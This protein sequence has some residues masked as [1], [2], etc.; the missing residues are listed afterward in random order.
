MKLRLTGGY[1]AAFLCL[2]I[3]CGTSHEFVNHFAG[4]L[5]CGCWGYKT[6]NSFVLC[7][8]C[9]GN[10]YGFLA[11]MAGPAFTFGLM[12]IGWYE[13]RKALEKNQ[14]F[15]FALIFANFPVNRI[16][17]ALI[18]Y[19]DEQWV[20][21]HLFGDSRAAFWI[22]NLLIWLVA[23][24][25]LIYAYRI[26]KNQWKILWFAGFFLLP[27]AFV[28]L[29]AG[30]FLEDYLLLDK[31]FLASTVIGIPYLILLVEILSLAG[32]YGFK[33]S[34]YAPAKLSVRAA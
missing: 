21:R 27:F 7:E 31:K 17:F 26:I 19:N 16:F 20:A 22:T 18:G 6:F 15:G 14:Q 28:I 13:L 24:P 8:A 4:G 25:P 12:W 10:R 32:F 2:T 11:T 1:L 5:I 30:L 3:L 23:I 29:F 9:K 34:I 33:K